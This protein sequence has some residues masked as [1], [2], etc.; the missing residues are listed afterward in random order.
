[1]AKLIGLRASTRHAL[2]AW[3]SDVGGDRILAHRETLR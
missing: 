1:M 2:E 3:F